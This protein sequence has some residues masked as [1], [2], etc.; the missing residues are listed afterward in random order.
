MIAEGISYYGLSDLIIVE[1]TMTDFAYGQTLLHYKN[2]YEEF[3]K[4]NKNIIFEQ[5][6]ASTHT[7]K[8]NTILANSLF[9]NDKWILCPPTSPDLAYLI[10]NLWAILK[11]NVKNRN[12]EN[13]EQ[14]KQFC[15]EEWNQINPK[16]YL[17]N[18][19][20]RVKMVLKINGNRLEDWHLKQIR[21]EEEEEE[22]EDE[23][24]GEKNFLIKNRKLKR[25]FNEVFLNNMKKREIKCLEKKKKELIDSY[26]E[27]IQQ[28]E[29]KT[30]KTKKNMA[31]EIKEDIGDTTFLE[32]NLL[33][34]NKKENIKLYEQKIKKLSDYNL[35][36][37]LKYYLKNKEKKKKTKDKD[38]E[39][40]ELEKE[41]GKEVEKE[42]EKEKNNEDEIQEDEETKVEL[43]DENQEIIDKIFELKK[44]EKREK[45]T[46]IL[47]ADFKKKT[48]K[49]KKKLNEL[50]AK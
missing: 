9:G 20:K 33:E 40:M 49:K 4:I 11:K 12:P 26:K 17:K 47:N 44:I 8:A 29:K 27:R 28:N 43:N 14:L 36:E 24:E 16:N 34:F 50:L 42:R 32:R 1:G 48:R 35:E 31:N 5:D 38:D 39:L 19:L 41:V 46:Y 7:S 18:F 3:K 15:I 2:N 25:V 6:R 23:E 21:K 30:I 45:F 13:Y 37:Y 22:E 10:E